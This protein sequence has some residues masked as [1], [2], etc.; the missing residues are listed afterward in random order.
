MCYITEVV[1]PPGTMNDFANVSALVADFQRRLEVIV[2]RDG[3]RHMMDAHIPLDV[4]DVIEN[5]L[6]PVLEDLINKI[7]WEPSDEDLVPGE[8]PMTQSEIHE[9]ARA[10]HIKMHS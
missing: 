10:M 9:I 3:S 8:P 4:M 2:K 1:A 6:Q 7:E 5:E